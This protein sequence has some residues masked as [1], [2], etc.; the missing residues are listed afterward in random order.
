MA[1]FVLSLVAVTAV[2]LQLWQPLLLAAVLSGTLSRWHDRLAAAWA[3]QRT[4]SAAAFTLGVVVVILV[5]VGV[6]A[7]FVVD[8][9]M[10]LVD[11]VRRTLAAQGLP[12][13]LHPL[14]DPLERWLHER[15]QG[16][17]EKPAA[18]VAQIQSWLRSGWAVSALASVLKEASE[19]LFDLL[20]MLIATFFLLRDGHQLVGWVKGSSS[21]PGGDLDELLDELVS[22]SKSVIGGNVLTGFAQATAATVGYVVAHVPSPLF[23]GLLTFLASFV[24]SVGTAMIGIPAALLLLLFGRTW[25]AVFLGAWMLMVVGLIDNLLRPLLMRGRSNLHGALVFFSLMG[26]ILLL[27]GMGLVVGPL[28]LVFFLTMTSLLRR[29]RAR[30]RAGV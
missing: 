3:G 4:L 5:P 2:G 30:E 12:G 8:Q 18:V 23:I 7:F 29:R 6:A 24:P 14:P 27:G 9:A 11:L 25:E 21:I 22:A 26:G 20:M 10:A 16:S 13:L 19:V 28:A 17:L 1:L 15:Y